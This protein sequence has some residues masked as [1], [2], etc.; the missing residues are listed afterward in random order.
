METLRIK[1]L[2]KLRGMTLTEL[3][4]RMNIHRVNLS[5]SIKNN[6][7]LD[8]LIE[9]ADILEVNI[10]ELFTKPEINVVNGYLEYEEEIYKITKLSDLESLVEKIKN[11]NN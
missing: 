1:E 3:S 5:S 6:P 2:L 8:R 11:R 4:V 10:S 9:I 7:T